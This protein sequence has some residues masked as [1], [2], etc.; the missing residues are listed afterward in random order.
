MLV[1]G[2]NRGVSALNLRPR[3][4]PAR[5]GR[6]TVHVQHSP[7]CISEPPIEQTKRE[8]GCNDG[9]DIDLD[10]K[11]C[12]VRLSTGRVEYGG[13][14][15]VLF[16]QLLSLELGS[17]A[18]QHGHARESYEGPGPWTIHESTGLR[19]VGESGPGLSRRRRS[20]SILWASPSDEWTAREIR[21]RYW[22]APTFSI[23]FPMA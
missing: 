4:L 12:I 22:Q 1:G 9:S 2:Q 6:Q 21:G 8:T 15:V 18:Q 7:E 10:S 13:Q 17:T 5:L 23:R 14:S 19:L 3:T 16:R 20:A 11:L